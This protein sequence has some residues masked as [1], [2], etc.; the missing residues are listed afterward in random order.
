VGAQGP[1]GAPVVA[2][3]LQLE[4]S[5]EVRRR[6]L[7]CTSAPARRAPAGERL[8]AKRGSLVGVQTLHRAVVLLVG[9]AHGVGDL[10]EAVVEQGAHRGADVLDV[11]ATSV[12][13]AVCGVARG[14]RYASHA[15]TAYA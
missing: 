1:E 4:R 3:S 12:H 13:N 14:A 11:Q 9:V 10:G 6:V 7:G 15:G 8:S 5:R 2:R